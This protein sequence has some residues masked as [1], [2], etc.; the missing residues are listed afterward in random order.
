M[1]Y[2]DYMY[3]ENRN[4]SFSISNMIFLWKSANDL[5]KSVWDLHGNSMQLSISKAMPLATWNNFLIFSICMEQRKLLSW[6]FFI[7]NFPSF[8]PN[9]HTIYWIV[10]LLVLL[11]HFFSSLCLFQFNIFTSI[12]SQYSC[13][14]FCFMALKIRWN[15]LDRFMFQRANWVEL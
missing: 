7:D 14:I 6:F 8:R 12:Y 5:R 13:V 15:S 1:F 11:C 10:C 2:Y 4:M 9:A 3:I